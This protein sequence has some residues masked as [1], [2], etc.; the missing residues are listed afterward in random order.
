MSAMPNKTKKD[1]VRH[2]LVFECGWKPVKVRKMR[3]N[4][5]VKVADYLPLSAR[6]I[7]MYANSSFAH[8]KLAFIAVSYTLGYKL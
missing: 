7:S 1:K 5:S 3:I 8:H 6:D 2:N 4:T